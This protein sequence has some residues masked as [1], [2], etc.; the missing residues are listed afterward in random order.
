MASICND[1]RA[2]FG[3]MSGHDRK[4]LSLSVPRRRVLRL[5]AVAHNRKNWHFCWTEVGARHAAIVQ[6]LIATC[7]LQGV[8]P[9]T[10]FVDV[11][12]RVGQQPAA[13]VAELTP[14]RWRA[15][16]ADTPL[17]SDLHGRLRRQVL[18]L[19]TAYGRL[20]FRDLRL[21]ARFE[22]E[23]LVPR[24]GGPAPHPAPLSRLHIACPA[25]AT[26]AC[27]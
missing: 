6:S 26:P 23:L 4:T 8:D 15:L 24:G 21:H 11:L 19:L 1:E 5:C 7:R 13:R 17:R 22:A 25:P 16:F 9:Y 3:V 10:C 2:R 27:L 12:Q 18:R 14:R 20:N